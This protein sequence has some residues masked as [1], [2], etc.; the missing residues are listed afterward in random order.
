MIPPYSPRFPPELDPIP[1]PSPSYPIE[2]ISSTPTVF[3]E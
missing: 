3:K 1:S 2:I